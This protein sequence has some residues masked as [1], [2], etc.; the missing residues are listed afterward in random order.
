MKKSRVMAFVTACR[1]ELLMPTISMLFIGFFWGL[2]EKINLN[3][4]TLLL[5]TTIALVLTNLQGLHINM[6]SDYKLD[7]KHKYKKHLPAAIDALGKN[8]FKIIF[9]SE[10][11][12]AFLLVLYL[13]VTLNKSI[14]LIM[15]LIGFFLGLA[16]SLEPF[17]FKSN[18]VLHPITLVMVLCVLPMVWVYYIFASVITLPFILFC[19]GIAIG[20]IAL[21]LPADLNDYPEDNAMGVRNLTQTLGPLRSS[22]F[23]ICALIACIL[24]ASTGAV[25]AFLGTGNP[26]LFG[27][28]AALVMVTIHCFALK[29]LFDLTKICK[30]HENATGNEQKK[31]MAKIKTFTNRAPQWI[32]LVACSAIFAC[33]LLY[34]S[35][36]WI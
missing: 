30:Q 29:K 1:P 7:K 26:W 35:K 22:K 23:S 25:L 21:V 5:I 14:L 3:S 16:Y 9:L 18:P 31:I 28:P 12:I 36:I 15:W 10:C 6:L 33:F 2:D 11:I 8:T 19:V 17:R 4:A 20:V 27:P 32:I 24:T 13:T 34:I